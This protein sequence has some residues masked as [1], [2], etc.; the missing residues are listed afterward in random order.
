VK[1][2]PVAAMIALL[3]LGMWVVYSPQIRHTLPPGAVTT[4]FVMGGSKGELVMIPQPGGRVF[5]FYPEKGAPGLQMSEQQFRGVV[6]QDGADEAIRMLDQ[7]VLR[8]LNV[9]SWGGLI[10]LTIGFAGQLLFFGR[11]FVQW[12]ASERSGQS[13]IPES[14]WWFSLV[15][16]I[17]LFTYFAWRRDPVGVLG[18]TSGVVIYAR[19][20][21]LIYK[22][23]RREARAAASTPAAA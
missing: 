16:G 11:M 18:Q 20:I 23:R 15:G 13:H 6:G 9:T 22:R 2:E 10:W 17:M 1:W 14:F 12:V 8:A 7:P 19:N 5:Q 4:R 21:R 3:L